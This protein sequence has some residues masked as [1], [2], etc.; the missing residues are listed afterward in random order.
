MVALVGWSAAT[1]LHALATSFAGLTSFR[2]L[3]GLFEAP[4]FPANSA[5][6]GCWFPRNERGMAVGVYTAAEYIAL[7]FLSPVLFWIIH[8]FGWRSLFLITG[9]I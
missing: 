1:F 5:I 9:T 6:I 4:C 7:G 2:L 8:T 3:L